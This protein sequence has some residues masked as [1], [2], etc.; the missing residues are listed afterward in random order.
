MGEILR[1]L[2]E[3]LFPQN[4]T[5]ELCGMEIFSGRLCGECGK[6]FELNDGETC[7]VCGRK[8]IRSEICTE[9]KAHLPEYKKA[10]SAVCYSGAGA[11]LIAKF[12]DG[13]GYLAEY[14]AE[15]LKPKLGSLPPFDAI[16]YIPMTKK[17]LNKRGY[18]QSYL[19]AKS[20]SKITGAP[21]LIDAVVKIKE[22]ALQ[23]SL[24]RAERLKNLSECFKA[25]KSLVSGKSLLVADDVL[26]TGATL[27]AVCSK[28]K[29]AGAKEVCA[30]TAASVEYLPFTPARRLI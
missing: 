12:K 2:K 26:T 16:V 19:L 10:V 21:V 25:D 23:K 30:A 20:I 7:P 13:G 9:C 22:T 27:D 1:F 14:F 17:A 24:G 3:S 5:C 28:L 4:Y 8:T 15:I 11:N 6:T 29:K 18:N